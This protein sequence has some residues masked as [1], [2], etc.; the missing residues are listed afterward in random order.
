MRKYLFLFSGFMLFF[1]QSHAQVTLGGDSSIDFSNPREYEIGGLTVTGI[2]FLDETVLK[3][4]SGLS[5]GDKIKVPGDQ[6]AKAVE[7]LWKQGLLSDIKIVA[8]KVEGNLIFIE[9]QLKEMPRLSR[10]SFKG[11][12]KNEVDKV[13]EKMTLVSGK[14]IT[15]NVIKTNESI[16]R[17]YF[18]DKGY[19]N[20]DVHLEEVTDSMLLNSSYIIIHIK[21]NGKVKIHAI[22]FYGNHQFPAEK[23]KRKMKDTKEKKWYSLFTTSKF[24]EETFEADKEKVIQKYLE[25]GFRDARIVSDSVYKYSRRTINIDIHISEGHKYYFRNISWIG[26][27]KYS[28]GLLDTIVNIKKGDL[29]DQKKLEAVLFMSESGRDISS[30]YMDDGYLFFQVDPVEVMV[31]NDSI[32]IEMRI[33]EGK[34]ARI[35]KVT[36]MG[37]TK[38]NDR[39]I[40]REIRTMPGQLFNRSDVIRSQRELAQL[41]YFDPEKLGVNPKPNPVD[42]TVDIEYVV[43]EKPSDQL[44][45]SGGYGAGQIVGT[46]GVSFNNFSARNITK[47][48]SWTPLP[49]GDGQKLSLRVQSNGI[50]YT[51]YNASFTE[52]WLGGRKPNSL[53]LS[54]FQSIQSNGRK[55]NDPTRSSIGITGG[56]IGLGKRLKWPD[57]YFTLFHEFSYQYYQLSNY[58]SSTFNFNDGYSNNISFSETVGRNSIDAPIW[59][60]RGSQLSFTVQFTPPYSLL[61]GR[62][63]KSAPPQQKYRYVEYHKW[64]FTQSW[65]TQ[66]GRIFK[67]VLNTRINF[68]FLGYYNKDIGQ[69]PFE[70]FYLGGDGL[71]GYS[72]DGRDIISLRGYNNNSLNPIGGGTIYDK[73]TMELRYPISTNP[74]ATI[75][76]L[77]FA[78]AGNAWFKFNE[79]APFD[80]KRSAGGGVRIFLPMFGLLGL[81]YGWGFDNEPGYNFPSRG[82]FHFSIGQQF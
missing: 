27:T 39:V 40:M 55:R 33:H 28:T 11:V 16:I 68:G 20:V 72:L 13:K 1:I 50:Y 38:T 51:S 54:F 64:T 49:S 46:L 30:L 3:T 53:S 58:S 6:L 18:I 37:N 45:L 60:T 57:D 48:N 24:D 82:H 12:T 66:M 81:D 52:P 32:D 77:G 59:T 70:R 65:F 29:Y 42:G 43:E 26:N 21:K 2:Q 44:E 67:M 8:T 61:N 47:K 76:L 22:N 10:F 35:N 17:N 63:Y 69:S 14:V 56:S 4:L 5:V 25:K 19:L 73:F 9:L 71:S 7:S 15:E 80:V 74:Q 36:V 79:F 41:G 34:Q 31:E 78:E 62:N 75:Y 23:L